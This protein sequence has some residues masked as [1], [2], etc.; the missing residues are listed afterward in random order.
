MD[1]ASVVPH[2]FRFLKEDFVSAMCLMLVVI[3]A[4]TGAPKSKS[5]QRRGRVWQSDIH[6][7]FLLWLVN[8]AKDKNYE[9]VWSSL[10]NSFFILDTIICVTFHI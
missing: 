4:V 2:L 9:G 3:Q 7:Y 10:S 8:C 6:T 5:G 1:V